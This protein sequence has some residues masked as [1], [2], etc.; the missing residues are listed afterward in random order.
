MRILLI[1]HYAGS[2]RMGMEY[3]PFYL[4]REWVIAGHDPTV[5]AA[6]FSHVRSCQPRVS[7]DLEITEEEGVRFRWLRTGSYTRSGAGRVMNIAAF[8]GKLHLH[9]ARIAREHR[10][11][12]VICS[13]T[14]PLDIYAGAHIAR[15]ANARLVFEVHDLWP[16]TPILLGRYSP[17]HP[18][19]RVLQHA[20][21]WAYAH[22]DVV[23]SILPDACGY[24]VE[25]GLDPKKFV[26]VPNGVCIASRDTADATVLPS[27][28]SELI[29][30]ERARG[31]FLVGYA[32]SSA[33]SMSLETLLGTARLLAGAGAA[34]VLAGGGLGFSPLQRQV[35]QMQLDNFHILGRIPKAAVPGFLASMDALTIAWRHSRLY[36]FGVSPNKLFDY[37]LAGRPILQASAASNDLVSEAGCGF[38]VPPEDPQALADAVL[39]LRRMPQ[40]ERG[41]LGE[42][43]RNFV[44]RRHNYSVLAHQFL[45]AIS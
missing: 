11:E 20:E 30:R 3:R 12:V 37:M 1:N 23:I 29:S 43:G 34:F 2:E 33:L 6:D 35:A 45:D 15:A 4:A 19:I 31:R 38:T 14:Y 28:L 13:S 32:G 21:D 9:T 18:F 40:A 8:V 22:A 44:L 24:M 36:Q 41:M 5:V 39:R 26:H 25:R 42:N 7:A 16:L 10:P 17:R 27:A